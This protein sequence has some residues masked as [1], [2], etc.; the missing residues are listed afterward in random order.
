MPIFTSFRFLI[1]LALILWLLPAAGQTPRTYTTQSYNLDLALTDTLF[2]TVLSHLERQSSATFYDAD[3][4]E[5]AAPVA[6]QRFVGYF[7]EQVDVFR[8]GM[9]GTV[10]MVVAD[11]DHVIGLGLGAIGDSNR[12][13]LTTTV[14]TG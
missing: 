8:V 14:I 9:M 1:A 11:G 3:T 6:H 10:L 2:S 7:D 5:F 13:L 12:L 4:E